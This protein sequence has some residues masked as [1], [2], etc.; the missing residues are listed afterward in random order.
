ME[1]YTVTYR[2]EMGHRRIAVLADSD[3]EAR[4]TAQKACHGYG[5]MIAQSDIT[6]VEGP[7]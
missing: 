2:T 4:D 5:I 3:Q 1:T 7:K 6:R